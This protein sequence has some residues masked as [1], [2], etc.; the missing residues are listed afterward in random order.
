M[1]RFSLNRWWAFVLTLCLF[2]ACSFLFI[3][4]TPSVARADYGIYLP[5]DDVPPPQPGL[6][7]PDVPI[8]PATGKVSAIKIARTGSDRAAAGARLS[9]VGDGK[10]SAS[11]WMMRLRLFLLGLRNCFLRY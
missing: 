6:G 3:A 4:Q 11:V 5:S 10:A 9:P 8:T 1:L 7:D 2:T